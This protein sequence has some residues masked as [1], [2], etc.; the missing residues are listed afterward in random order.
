MRHIVG[1]RGAATW[2]CVPRRINVGPARNKNAF[3][4]FI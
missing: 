2:P 1:P 3:F 4:A